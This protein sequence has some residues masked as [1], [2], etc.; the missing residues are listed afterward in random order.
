MKRGAKQIRGEQP[1]AVVAARKKMFPAQSDLRRLDKQPAI[2]AKRS[3]LRDH[4]QGRAL[5]RGGHQAI[6]RV[7]P[8]T[9]LQPLSQLRPRAAGFCAERGKGQRFRQGPGCPQGACTEMSEARAPRR[10]LAELQERIGVS[11]LRCERSEERRVG[12]EW[13]SRRARYE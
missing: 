11:A 1:A 2:T 10:H 6:R 7:K 13:R 12:K 5:F 3:G 4:V 9:G 8:W